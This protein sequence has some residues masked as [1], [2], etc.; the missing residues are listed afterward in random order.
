MQVKVLSRCQKPQLQPALEALRNLFF[1]PE[2]RTD[3]TPHEF[4]AV[5]EKYMAAR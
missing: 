1:I 3:V 2:Y 5:C 4:I